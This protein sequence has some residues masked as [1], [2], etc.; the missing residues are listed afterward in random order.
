MK[1]NQ[2]LVKPLQLISVMFKT[3]HPNNA[4]V[5]RTVD[6]SLH[7]VLQ[8]AET[9]LADNFFAGT[10]SFFLN[11]V[12]SKVAICQHHSSVGGSSL[13]NDRIFVLKP[14]NQWVINFFYGKLNGIGQ[15][16][17]AESLIQILNGIERPSCINHC[18][19]LFRQCYGLFRHNAVAVS[20]KTA[21]SH[22]EPIYTV[23]VCIFWSP[24]VYLQS[25]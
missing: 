2:P 13:A 6:A 7:N 4:T 16:W 21:V 20:G 9:L 15:L 17:G 14:N 5:Q 25:H 12:E 24:S 23:P 19:C 11:S 3:L 18:R 8:N 22:I 1:P 10:F